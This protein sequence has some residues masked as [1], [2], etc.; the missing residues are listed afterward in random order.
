MGTLWFVLTGFVDSV[1]GLLLL[2]F[3]VRAIMSWVSPIPQNKIEI[4]IYNVTEWFIDPIR[5][6]LSRFRFVRE[7]PIDLS[8]SVTIIILWLISSII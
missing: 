5:R 2:L 8:F 3:F 4:F 1:I 7:C 6:V